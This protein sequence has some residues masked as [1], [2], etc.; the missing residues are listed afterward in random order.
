MATLQPPRRS[1][2]GPASFDI[3]GHPPR[4]VQQRRTQQHVVQPCGPKVEVTELLPPADRFDDWQ[5]C[6]ENQSEPPTEGEIHVS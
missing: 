2:P 6:A 1:Q 3:P 5:R 4:T